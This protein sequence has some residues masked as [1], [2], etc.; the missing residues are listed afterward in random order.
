MNV[1]PGEYFYIAVGLLS[2][3]LQVLLISAVIRQYRKFPIL[4]CYAVVSF[5]ATVME[6][7]IYLRAFGFS[8]EFSKDIYWIN[9]GIIQVL[10]YLLVVSLMGKTLSTG[11]QKRGFRF[12][13]AVAALALMAF[14]IVVAYKPDSH[15]L[16]S[17]TA[18]SRNLSFASAI[19]NLLLWS[20]LLATKKRDPQLLTLSTGLG[21][22]TTGR[23]IG[24]SLRKIPV[25][26]LKLLGNSLMVLTYMLSFVILW[27]ALHKRKQSDS[28]DRPGSEE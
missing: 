8:T 16:V 19:L 12:D 22:Q 5:L 10:V 13:Y 4:A 9:E 21:V 6:G 1:G 28:F 17:M 20:M 7:A 3:F 23:A 14:C 18:A 27:W 2:A 11:T 24:H 26:E 15:Y 25:T